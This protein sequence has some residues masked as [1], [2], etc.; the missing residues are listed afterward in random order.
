MVMMLIVVSFLVIDHPTYVIKTPLYRFRYLVYVAHRVT[1]FSAIVWIAIF[2]LIGYHKFGV[3]GSQRLVW[4][5]RCWSVLCMTV[6]VV[7]FC[8]IKHCLKGGG[9]VS[10]SQDIPEKL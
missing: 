1:A 5:R 6:G 7:G 4:L 3:L 10:G 2:L 8:V 9:G